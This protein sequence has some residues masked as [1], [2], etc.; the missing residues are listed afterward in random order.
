MSLSDYQ[1]GA[2]GQASGEEPFPGLTH[3]FYAN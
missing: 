1:W 2:P 3:I